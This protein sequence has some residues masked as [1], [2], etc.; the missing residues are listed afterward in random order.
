MSQ[1]QFT[2]RNQIPNPKKYN[3][4]LIMPHPFFYPENM[5]DIRKNR[6]HGFFGTPWR[7]GKGND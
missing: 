4:L 2:G 3:G 5:Q 6:I 7:T 1:N